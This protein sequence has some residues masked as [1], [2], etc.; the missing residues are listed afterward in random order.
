LRVP[1]NSIS[2]GVVSSCDLLY[3]PVSG[4]A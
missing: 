3:P 4:N 2:A 1:L